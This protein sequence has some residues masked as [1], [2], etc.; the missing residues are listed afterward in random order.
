MK[1][2]CRSRSG[3]DGDVVWEVKSF[4]YCWAHHSWGI[5]YR[6]YAAVSSSKN[7]CSEKLNKLSEQVLKALQAYAESEVEL[8]IEVTELKKYK[9]DYMGIGQPKFLNLKEFKNLLPHVDEVDPKWKKVINQVVLTKILRDA[10]VSSVSEK[11]SK[12]SSKNRTIY[13]TSDAVEKHPES[14]NKDNA[15]HVIKYRAGNDQNKGSNSSKNNNGGKVT[16]KSLRNEFP[17][18]EDESKEDWGNR[19]QSIMRERNGD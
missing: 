15:D 16:I 1:R 7:R 11:E 5:G 10:G 18:E 8:A 19:L 12:K 6:P 17:K 4:W 9:R 13:S 2:W 14:F 3:N